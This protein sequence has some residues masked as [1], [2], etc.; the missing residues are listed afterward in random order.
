MNDEILTK[1]EIA[2]LLKVSEI[3]ID[4]WRKEGLPAIKVRSK[5]LFNKKDVLQWLSEKSE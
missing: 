5:V 2:Q 1:Q 4:R 3:T